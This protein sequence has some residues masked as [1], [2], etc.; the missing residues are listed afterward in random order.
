MQSHFDIA[1]TYGNLSDNYLRIKKLDNAAA[2]VREAIRTVSAALSRDPDYLQGQGNLGMAYTTYA[3]IFLAKRDANGAL[4]NYRRALAILE[5]EPVRSAQTKTLAETY[6]GLG[7]ADLLR[8]SQVKGGARQAGIIKEAQGWYQRS[9]DVW[10]GLDQQGKV[11]GED[12]KNLSEI[13]QKIEQCKAAW[14]KLKAAP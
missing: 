1:A 5:R 12:Q 9:L 7:N 6:A 4:E 8:V 10:H 3:E 13:A 11:A 2:S 14:T